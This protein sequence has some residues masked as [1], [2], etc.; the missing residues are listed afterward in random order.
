[1]RKVTIL[2]MPEVLSLIED[3]D[4]DETPLTIRDCKYIFLSDS[5]DSMCTCYEGQ[6]GVY[7]VHTIARK[8]KGR[9]AVDLMERSI[10]FLFENG[11]ATLVLG[12]AKGLKGWKRLL[13]HSVGDRLNYIDLPNDVRM[14]YFTLDDYEEN[15]R[16]KV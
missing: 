14:Y 4:T 8:R 2:E 11:G 1:M 16:R 9:E 13:A 5:G 12:L 6:P 15:N 10:V 7:H 3:T